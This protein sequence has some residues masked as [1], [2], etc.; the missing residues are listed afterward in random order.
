MKNKT[1]GYLVEEFDNTG[2]LVWSAFMA[3]KPTSLEIEKDIKNKLHNWVITPLIADTK[4]VITISNQ[5][6]YDSKRLID[7][8]NGH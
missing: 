2:K 7:A 8:Y 1:L 3:S 5:K 6:K 4:N